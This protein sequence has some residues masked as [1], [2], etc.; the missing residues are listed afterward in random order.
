M[1]STQWERGQKLQALE[2]S[3]SNSGPSSLCSQS[4][5][6]PNRNNSERLRPFVDQLTQ[7]TPLRKDRSTKLITICHPEKVGGDPTCPPNDIDDDSNSD[8]LL[9]LRVRLLFVQILRR[10]FPFLIPSNRSFCLR[11]SPAEGFR[12]PEW[13]YSPRR[14]LKN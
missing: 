6:I 12:K 9:K 11:H 10:R 1:R 3:G 13:P 8:V 14:S 7:T 2:H 5:S 4:N